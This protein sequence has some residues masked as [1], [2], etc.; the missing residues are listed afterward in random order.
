MPFTLGTLRRTAVAMSLAS[1]PLIGLR[2]QTPAEGPLVSTAWLADHLKDP[3]LVVLHV[4][5]V[6]REYTEG[7]IPGARFVWFGAVAPS[8]PD[9]SSE[10]PSGNDIKTLLENA[11]VSDNSRIVIYGASVSPVVTRLYMTLDYL[12]AGNRTSLL[13]GG[14]TAWKAEGRTTSTDVPQVTRGKF[15]PHVHADAVVDANFVKT[16]LEKPGVH[17]IDARAAQ[18]YNGNGGGMPR[19]GHIPSAM[20]I[21]FTTVLDSAGKVKDKSALA[22]L[23]TAAG[24]TPADRV[25]SYCHI[26]QQATMI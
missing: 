24:V 3:N 16:N 10:L 2:S 23:F 13:D 5:G 20:N 1:I 25:V 6:R 17:I 15:T 12:G 14:M 8:N 7:H 22:A 26:G 4:A 18:F 19:A 21:P 9:L 11:G